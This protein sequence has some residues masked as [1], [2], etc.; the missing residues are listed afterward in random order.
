[1]SEDTSAPTVTEA[2]GGENTPSVTQEVAPEVTQEVAPKK[3]RAKAKPDTS[4]LGELVEMA[5]GISFYIR[6]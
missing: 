6:S 5:P 3:S 4:E 1:M 2:E